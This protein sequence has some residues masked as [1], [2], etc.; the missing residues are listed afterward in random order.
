ME[1]R[2]GVWSISD[3][4]NNRQNR[5]RKREREKE[6][7]RERERESAERWVG[8]YGRPSNPTTLKKENREWN[9]NVQCIRCPSCSSQV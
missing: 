1:V 8:W 4:K 3:I 6:R 2:T 9:D 7:V 5:E